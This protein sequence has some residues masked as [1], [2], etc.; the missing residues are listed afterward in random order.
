MLRSVLVE[1]ASWGLFLAVTSSH[2]GSEV[3]G[4]PYLMH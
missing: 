4:I 3:D 2:V 1:V